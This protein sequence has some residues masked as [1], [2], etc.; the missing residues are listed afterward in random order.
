[1]LVRML[2]VLL[3]AC[4]D[5]AT[6]P[7]GP[8]IELPRRDASVASAED[9]QACETLSDPL[10]CGACGNACPSG[11][12]AA[13]RCA[14]GTCALACEAGF[15]DCN[16]NAL[17]G[18]E[19]DL[20]T[21]VGHCGACKRDCRTCGGTACTAGAC[22][23][24]TFLTRPAPI[25]LLSVDADHVTFA[26][27]EEINQAT[28]PSAAVSNVYGVAKTPWLA[29]KGP[30]VLFV[31][32]GKEPFT[33]IYSTTA[34]FVGPQIAAYAQGDNVDTLAIDDTG[35]YWAAETTN[36]ARKLVRCKDC[37]VPTVLAPAENEL[38]PGAIALD[39]TTV[40]FG[41]GDMIRRVEKTGADLKTLAVSQSARTMAVDAD[42]IYWI[43]DLGAGG[44]KDVVRL[45]KAGGTPS[46]L[47]TGLQGSGFLVLAGEQLYVGDR[48]VLFRI[49]KDGSARLDLATAPDALGPVATD[50]TCVW[51]GAA[52]DIRQ[53]SR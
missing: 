12:H 32:P 46:V 25:T 53:I 44:A 28:R 18:C 47:A 35:V 5:D 15:G 45:P 30:L 41:S 39:A 52:N 2:V 36:Q 10:N 50:G 29:T 51:F 27:A 9:A 22:N 11:A 31:Y 16:G 24:K 37:S 49:E 6:A 14:G 19:T 34:G 33:G 1:M 13:A 38:R 21:D 7:E 43:N 42:H 23:A 26:D 8:P 48:S 3:G 20:R 17:D 40:Y 4:G